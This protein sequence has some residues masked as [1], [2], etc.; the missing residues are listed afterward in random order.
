MALKVVYKMLYDSETAKFLPY[1]SL[2]LVFIIYSSISLVLTT[3]LLALPPLMSL[4]KCR[5]LLE[6]NF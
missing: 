1:F 5:P 2:L 3:A 6:F 4:L